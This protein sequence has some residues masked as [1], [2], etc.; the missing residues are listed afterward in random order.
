MAKNPTTTKPTE[1]GW[2]WY[3]DPCATHWEGVANITQEECDECGTP[4]LWVEFG[5]DA[6]RQSWSDIAAGEY[7]WAPARVPPWMGGA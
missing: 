7:C 5:T 6:L 4:V 1:T 3:G 2:Y